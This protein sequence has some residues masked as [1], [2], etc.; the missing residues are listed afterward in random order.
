M[1]KIDAGKSSDSRSSTS[2]VS[3]KV[4]LP[5]VNMLLRLDSSLDGI[6]ALS[7]CANRGRNEYLLTR[8]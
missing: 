6:K 5:L 2:W 8:Q 4:S 3:V 7:W 1:I